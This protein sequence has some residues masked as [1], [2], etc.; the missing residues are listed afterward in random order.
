MQHWQR[1]GNRGVLLLEKGHY[2]WLC[3]HSESR[4]VSLDR[5]AFFYLAQMKCLSSWS[6]R[7][8][9]GLPPLLLSIEHILRLGII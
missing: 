2:R 9:L 4:H 7:L 5:L 1:S 6:Q 8:F 3:R